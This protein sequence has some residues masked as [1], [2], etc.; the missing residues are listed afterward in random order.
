MQKGIRLHLSD[1]VASFEDGQ[2]CAASQVTLKS[3]TTLKADLVILAMGVRPV[4]K[5]VGDAGIELT[6]RGHIKVPPLCE[7][8]DGPQLFLERRGPLEA[9]TKTH[10]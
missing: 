10:P 8:T 7:V 9:L 3:G 4:T 2:D 5:F 1:P 6:Q